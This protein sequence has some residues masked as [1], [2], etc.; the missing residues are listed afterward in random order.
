MVHGLPR[1]RLMSNGITSVNDEA[2]ATR[3]AGGIDP[4]QSRVPRWLNRLLES[5]PKSL[6]I[7]IGAII[8]ANALADWRIG[9]DLSLG[10]FYLFPIMA[11]AAVYSRTTI[12][13]LSLGCAILRLTFGAIA[14]PLEMALNFT[15]VITSYVGA[16]FFVREMVDSRKRVAV[17]AGQLQQQ[18]TL[19]K[20]AED[21]LRI[22][23]DSSPAAIMTLGQ[24]G[25]ILATNQAALSLFGA[26]AEQDLEKI[27]IGSLLPVLRD[28]LAI[29]DTAE[30]FRTAAQ[31]QGRRL[32]GS[33]FH[34]HIWFST[35]ET[36]EGR[37]LAAIA[38]DSSDEIREREENALQH[39]LTSNR[40]LTAAVLHEIRNLCGSI[41]TAYSNLTTD[42]P[43]PKKR[44]WHILG[45]M[46][47]ALGKLASANLQGASRESLSAI[48][49]SNFLDQ[50]RI[51]AKPAW[52]EINGE[53]EIRL[54]KDLPRVIADSQGLL[55]VLLNLMSNSIR[56]VESAPTRKMIVLAEQR[57]NKIVLAV[58]DSGPGIEHPET[59]FVP[60]QH[61]A[62]RVGLGLY[63]SR[64]LMRS[65]G[66][67]LRHI[68]T[69]SG[70]RFEL[71]LV[72][73]EQ[74]GD[75]HVWLM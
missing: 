31:C 64:A 58:E 36:P 49:P 27:N 45:S 43:S 13:L 1:L 25:Q 10:V 7:G 30:S 52:E 39:L 22:L 11:A 2:F 61:G 3:T 72:A 67:E 32:D 21:Q 20:Q 37:R 48:R 24:D 6:G 29:A 12:A 33:P 62:E 18:Q 59:L 73:A 44:E 8:V 38:V 65:F 47:E 4:A 74:P 42:V 63:L 53:L 57:G 50:F 15:L 14:S 41:S 28:A 56:A 19:R 75:A 46:I 5:S 51:I 69:E 40:V 68:S 16:G 26:E 55:Q 9:L 66:G 54:D 34:A 60:F 35:Y 70:C 23:A 17:F 71:E